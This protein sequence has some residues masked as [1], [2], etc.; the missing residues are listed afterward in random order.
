MNED[1]LALKQ[2]QSRYKL[3]ECH[4]GF[5]AAVICIFQCLVLSEFTST[6]LPQFRLTV[7]KALLRS[8]IFQQHYSA[9][10]EDI[11]FNMHYSFMNL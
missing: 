3:I 2:R 7:F 8:V 9:R 10:G 1:F 5:A 6:R 4:V 11:H